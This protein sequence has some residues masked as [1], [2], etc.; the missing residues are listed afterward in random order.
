MAA[1]F[2]LIRG[3]MPLFG[4]IDN[5]QTSLFSIL[6]MNDDEVLAYL[7]L[8][9]SL[10]NASA[11]DAAL[12]AFAASGLGIKG[13]NMIGE[14]IANAFGLDTVTFDGSGGDDTAL[15]VGKYLLP[16]LYLSYGIGVFDSVSTVNLRDELSKWWSLKAESG[17]ETGVDLLYVREK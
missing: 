1:L 7:L 12:L 10:S 6:P 16:N 13:G 17:G 14:Q 3:G 9:R 8:G 4:T 11:T 5:L 15:H 2:L